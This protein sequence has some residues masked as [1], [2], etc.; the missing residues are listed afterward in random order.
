M[1]YRFS[2]GINTLVLNQ[3]EKGV[4][5]IEIV[6]GHRLD[7]NGVKTKAVKKTHHFFRDTVADQLNKCHRSPT[8]VYSSSAS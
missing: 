8:S 7:C 4:L 6:A 5:S 2:D 3:A 1:R